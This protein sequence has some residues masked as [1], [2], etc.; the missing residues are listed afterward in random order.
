VLLLFILQSLLTVRRKMA[1]EQEKRERNE[2]SKMCLC[3]N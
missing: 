3:V 1:K 2:K